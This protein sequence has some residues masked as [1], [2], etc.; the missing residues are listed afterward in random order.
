[1]EE[2]LIGKGSHFELIRYLFRAC[3]VAKWSGT[4]NSDLILGTEDLEPP[5]FFLF[6]FIFINNFLFY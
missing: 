2:D 1:M 5:L 4:D 6:Y 3:A